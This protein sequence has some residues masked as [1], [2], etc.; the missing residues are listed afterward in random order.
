M[1]HLTGN[2]INIILSIIIIIYL[3]KIDDCSCISHIKNEKKYLKEWYLFIIIWFI[4]FSIYSFSHFKNY[5]KTI[6]NKN[7]FNLF[8]NLPSLLIIIN[9]IIYIIHIFMLIKTLIYIKKLREI[10]CDCELVKYQDL[11]YYTII[12]WFSICA[13]FVLLMIIGIIIHIY[14]YYSCKNKK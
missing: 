9:I 13:F 4:I 14:Y 8:F 12:G 7:H 3:I 5:H 2:G 1:E 6:K 11:I 10:D